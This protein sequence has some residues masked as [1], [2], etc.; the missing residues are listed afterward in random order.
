M[1][2]KS[3]I[4]RLKEILSKNKNPN[5]KFLILNFTHWDKIINE[6]EFLEVCS[7]TFLKYERENETVKDFIENLDDEK[8]DL[9][10]VQFPLGFRDGRKD[11]CD[12]IHAL[13]DKNLN[14]NGCLSNIS[15]FSSFSGKHELLGGDTYI[16]HRENVIGEIYKPETGVRVSMYEFLKGPFT[17]DD[18]NFGKIFCSDF[19]DF[20]EQQND[21]NNVKVFS[22]SKALFSSALVTFGQDRQINNFKTK[23][24]IPVSIQ[25]TQLER[26]SVDLLKSNK[27][28]NKVLDKIKDYKNGVFIPMIPSK[29]NKCEILIEN[30]KDSRYWLVTFDPEIFL[31]D[32]VMNFL[33]SD[34]GK[35]QLLSLGVGNI[36]PHLN[37]LSL[38][39]IV[40]PMKNTEQQEKI[41]KNRKKI[42]DAQK[43]FNEYIKKVSENVED[44][45]FEF[46]PEELMEQV[47]GYSTDKLLNE[48]ESR[49][50]ERKSTLRFDL[51]Q[52]KIQGYITEL[53]LKTIVAF[54]NTDGGIL[55]VGQSD[56][57]QLVGIEADK[58]KNQDE[59]SKFLKD[60]IKTRIGIKFLETYI[61][62][63]FI[64][65]NDKTLIVITCT[66]LPTS[67]RAFLNEN[68]FWIRTGPG[69]E[70]LSIKETVEYI[71]T[72]SKI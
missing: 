35:E 5:K 71:V 65:H 42:E 1:M 50:F 12:Y 8:F 44:D 58:F 15:I 59:C 28:R 14:N 61:K 66:K 53:V 16:R 13:I 63:E 9:I 70:K 48:E 33:N 45:D 20:D 29:S 55:V 18:V 19:R 62:Y 40:L 23:N 32:Y 27:N 67:E 49:N 26:V 31:N 2:K 41:I 3:I 72:K 51:K 56:D 60:K 54:L 52:K 39:K 47:P 21:L 57:K 25:E 22:T 24:L 43:V 46:K 17:A 11:E 64:K 69:N 30:L 6:D 7:T 38:G 4:L 10:F 37:S 68:E 36:I 34:D